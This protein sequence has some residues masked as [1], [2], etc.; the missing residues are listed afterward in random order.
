MS[1]APWDTAANGQGAPHM[2]SMALR[3]GGAGVHVFPVGGKEPLTDH[4]FHDASN[5]REQIEAWWTRWPQA[6]I[7][8]PDFDVVD[9]DLYKPEC[10][11]T[12]ERVKPLIPDGT[13]CHK[14][15]GGGL[16]F[17]FKAGTLKDGK[18]GPGVDSRYAGR[19]YVVLP[20][21]LHPDG[22]RYEAV[23]SPLVRP[24][25][26]APAFPCENGSSEFRQLRDQIDAG[27]KIADGRN[28][29]AW[30]QAVRILRAMPTA[31]ISFV[32]GLVQSWV[33]ANCAGDLR[34]VDVPKQMRGAVKFVANER[35][36]KAATNGAVPS[37]I[38][39]TTGDQVEL[40]EIRF[41]DKPFWQ[42]AAFHEVIGR[43][44]AGKGTML[45]NL[46]ARV[47]RGEFGD[48]RRAIWIASG[49]DSYAIDVVPRL[50]AAGGD[51]KLLVVAE[52]DRVRL[53]DD[54]DEIEQ[55][56]RRW[57]DVG[58]IIIDPLAGSLTAG[59]STNIDGEVRPAIDPLNGLADRLDCMLAGVRHITNKE[60][61]GG[62]LAAV[63]GSSE[64][65]NVPRVVISIVHD[66]EDDDV[67]HMHVVAG[68]R[69]KHGTGRK[70]RIEG[71]RIGSF[72]EEVTK[73]VWL[74]ESE[75]DPDDLLLGGRRA[76]GAKSTDARELI[77]DILDAEAEVE[78][79]TLDARVA[80]ET[81]LAAKTVRNVRAELKSEGLLRSFPDKDE[82]GTIVRWKVART[83]APRP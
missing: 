70:F 42:H 40:R 24:P 61:K 57:G 15:G 78:S 72:E 10:A 66:R 62:S 58:L 51:P 46:A 76:N 59:T 49:E 29:A 82:A 44:N 50:I 52:G 75:E 23:I 17:I 68:N 30:W 3:Y 74:G 27:E 11:S 71:H 45:A 33:N 34:G 48:R 67:R 22:G 5:V 69:A 32:E 26:P 4:G 9:V 14:T 20:P 83:A 63:L 80:S 1:A 73:A 65:V 39:W 28:K 12:W 79:D 7:A 43:K 53:P 13:P 35:A 54:V 56:A 16:Q 77:L 38:E 55:E 60:A 8:T 64:W 41:A 18:I 81:G 21:S 2:L 37:G 19:N 25:G 47:T 36:A 31:D 6:G